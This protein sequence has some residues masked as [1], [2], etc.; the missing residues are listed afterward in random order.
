M[1]S[2]AFFKEHRNICSIPILNGLLYEHFHVH[3]FEIMLFV[4]Y[5]KILAM[6]LVSNFFRLSQGE[7]VS[8]F[9]RHEFCWVIDIIPQNYVLASKNV[10]L[11]EK[12]RL[13]ENRLNGDPP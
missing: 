11:C 12:S 7:S 9:F 2:Y 4:S 5:D 10:S 6:W 13:V 8:T 3:V 1:I